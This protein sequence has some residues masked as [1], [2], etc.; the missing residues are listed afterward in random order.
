MRADNA[1]I[2]HVSKHASCNNT[3]ARETA[4]SLV[5][6]TVVAC[7]KP[8][9]LARAAGSAV[10]GRASPADPAFPGPASPISSSNTNT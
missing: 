8:G 1:L 6:R 10:S 4:L 3:P 9:C 7:G 2:R 5:V